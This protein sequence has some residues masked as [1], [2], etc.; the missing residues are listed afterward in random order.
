MSRAAKSS[1]ATRSIGAP[2][3]ARAVQTR[4]ALA[5]VGRT[6]KSMSPVA[7]GSPWAAT[8]Y[9]P[10]MRYSTA[11]PLNVDMTSLKSGFSIERLAAR[12]GHHRPHADG[13][14]PYHFHA[15]RGREGK[16][17]FIIVV[18]TASRDASVR[19]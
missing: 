18:L 19:P 6:Q 11:A 4:C 14:R 1:T 16:V 10:K 2:N 5:R 9:A 3:L 7:R 13:Q 17:I 8:A 15:L 12:R